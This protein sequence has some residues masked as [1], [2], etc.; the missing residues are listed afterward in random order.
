M[1]KNKVG[2]LLFA[3]PLF[4]YASE[5]EPSI[6]DK[7]TQQDTDDQAA[8]NNEPAAESY[9]QQNDID[10]HVQENGDQK[11]GM[12]HA[13]A[14]IVTDDGLI[15]LHAE[16]IQDIFFEK[17][18]VG[19]NGESKNV[20]ALRYL[21]P[22]DE[23]KLNE[24]F[25]DNFGQEN[26]G[27]ERRE[28][29]ANDQSNNV[30]NDS[31]FSLDDE[32]LLSKAFNSEGNTKKSVVL[33]ANVENDNRSNNIPQ[34]RYI[35]PEDERLLNEVFNDFL[36][37]DHAV[38]IAKKDDNRL[39]GFTEKDLQELEKAFFVD[40]KKQET[41]K[42]KISTYLLLDRSMTLLGYCTLSAVIGFT[43]GNIFAFLYNKY[44]EQWKKAFQT[45]IHFCKNKDYRHKVVVDTLQTLP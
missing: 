27:T 25:N 28:R 36:K 19:S 2:I 1:I 45:F 6:I 39:H 35:S 9:M 24:S 20:R 22:V 43:V 16:Q 10:K 44:G 31:N 33:E 3:I 32:I 4:G 8:S 7:Q 5:G 34:L 37:S 14:F 38:Q 12:P 15:S 13:P 21:S 40:E 29:N 18:N 26:N 17:S 42:E 30:Q 23:Y 41:I 11:E